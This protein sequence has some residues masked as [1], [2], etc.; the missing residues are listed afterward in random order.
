MP[1]SMKES[2]VRSRALTRGFRIEKSRQQRHLN[3]CGEYMLIENNRNLVVLGERY[4]ATL[5][6]IA[7]YLEDKAA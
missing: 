5:E 4:D 7:G 3:N 6:D 2:A 1:F